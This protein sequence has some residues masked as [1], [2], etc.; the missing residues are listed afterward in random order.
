MRVRFLSR[1]RPR[2]VGFVVLC[3]VFLWVCFWLALDKFEPRGDALKAFLADH[4]CVEI[5]RVHG[6]NDIERGYVE[7]RC[8]DDIGDYKLYDMPKGKR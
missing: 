6:S 2:D 8:N 1:I 5:R 7:Y 3:L 4:G